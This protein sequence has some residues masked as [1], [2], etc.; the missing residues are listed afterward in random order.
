LPYHRVIWPLPPVMPLVS[1]VIPTRDQADLLRRCL[2]GI[3]HRTD[4][5]PLEIILVDNGSR[6]AEAL[7]LLVELERDSRVRVLRDD[8]PFNYSRLNNRAVQ[9][10]QGEVVLLLNN[11]TDV[12]HQD[13]LREMVS[14][15]VRPDVGTVGARLLFEDRRVQHG[16]V[17][18]GVGDFLDG[19]G[20]AGHFGLFSAEAEDGYFCEL[21]LTR[22]VS[23]NTGACLAFR[24]EVYMRVGGLDEINLAVSFND[25]DFCLR[26][27]ELG[28][29]NVWTPFA[30]LLHL[31]SASRGT[32]RLVAKA[33]RAHQEM[34]YMRFNWA[35][36]LDHDPY[37]NAHFSRLDPDHRLP[38]PGRRS[39]PWRTK[40]R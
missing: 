14:H 28:L 36:I 16:G 20:V 38:I 27:R 22:T 1:V 17:V 7:A 2:D 21:R 32:D 33:P 13:W 3:L 8:G 29:R 35:P 37:Y 10:A 9:L 19:P 39:A 15:A 40:T 18:L 6:D 24:K 11:D 25:V 5:E 30:E 34:K 26:V 4:Y 23:A 31:E 12:L